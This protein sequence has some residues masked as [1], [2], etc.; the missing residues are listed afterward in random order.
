MKMKKCTN[1]WLNLNIALLKFLN[2]IG[3]LHYIHAF[4]ITQQHTSPRQKILWLLTA[5]CWIWLLSKIFVN[6]WFECSFSFILCISCC[7]LTW[8][9]IILPFCFCSCWLS[10]L[11]VQGL[12]IHDLIHYSNIKALAS[13]TDDAT[14]EHLEC[15]PSLSHVLVYLNIYFCHLLQGSVI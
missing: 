12:G 14:L 7:F 1:L 5:S 10:L 11:S 6:L 4:I 8:S 13:S 9:G 2:M 3:S 15:A